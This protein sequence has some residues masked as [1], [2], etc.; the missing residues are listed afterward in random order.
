MPT[1]SSVLL[2]GPVYP[3]S[4]SCAHALTSFPTQRSNAP[5]QIHSLLPARSSSSPTASRSTFGTSRDDCGACLP[6]TR[7][8]H[9]MLLCYQRR[10]VLRLRRWPNGGAGYLDT[11]QLSRA[12][13]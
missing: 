6:P 13:E 8:R 2:R 9:A 11:S 1:P 5:A 7:T 4:L 3:S 10:L 12:S